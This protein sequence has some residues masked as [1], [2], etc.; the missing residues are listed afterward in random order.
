MA[1]DPKGKVKKRKQT[2]LTQFNHHVSQLNVRNTR[3]EYTS[4]SSQLGKP[5]IKSVIC[6]YPS[7]CT[8][9]QA[10]NPINAA[11]LLIMSG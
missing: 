10:I 9:I 2:V 7:S 3:V 5:M 4:Q 1:P 11:H 6:Y 8:Y